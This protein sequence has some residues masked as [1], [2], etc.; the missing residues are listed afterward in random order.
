MEKYQEIPTEHLPF[1]LSPAGIP[2]FIGVLET[3]FPAERA[4][5]ISPAQG[6]TGQYGNRKIVEPVMKS[7]L[8][9]FLLYL[10]V[11]LCI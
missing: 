3:V 7:S 11:D 8:L 1:M 6:M 10:L 4:V 9:T 5:R 2:L